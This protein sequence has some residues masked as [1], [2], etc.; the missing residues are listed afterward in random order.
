MGG[1]DG[2]GS[3]KREREHSKWSIARARNISDLKVTTGRV[4]PRAVAAAAWHHDIASVHARARTSGEQEKEKVGRPERGKGGR[5]IGNDIDKNQRL[6]L[7]D[8]LMKTLGLDQRRPAA[9]C[10][11]AQ[12]E[13]TSG[14]L[15]ASLMDVACK[16][17]RAG[18]IG[19]FPKSSP[20][21]SEDDWPG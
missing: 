15:D 7:M 6:T 9:G 18:A 4:T 3:R 17:A 20:P 10:T 5:G 8:S 19:R 2:M 14:Q 21:F 12:A 13:W 16:E 11:T 1:G